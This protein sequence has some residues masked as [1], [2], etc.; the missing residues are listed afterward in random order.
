MEHPGRLIRR[1]FLRVGV[2]ATVAL[3]ASHTVA[4]PDDPARSAEATLGAWIRA[5]NAGESTEQFFTSDA[6]LVRG[7]GV[8]VGS[9]R[10]A[11]MEHRESGAGLRLALKVQRTEQVG[12]DSA[13]VLGDYEVTVPGKD[14][15]PTQVVPG[16]SVH[17]LQRHGARW[18]LRVSS[19]TRVQAP[20]PRTASASN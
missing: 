19:F 13:W 2:L 10:I 17:V 9:R 4:Q 7:N 6:T 11:E 18:Q 5:F 1:H 15:G 16:V 12:P 20:A 8:F 3:I 14:G